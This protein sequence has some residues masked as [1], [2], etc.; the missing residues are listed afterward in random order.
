MTESESAQE[1]ADRHKEAGNSFGYTKNAD[2][3]I[4]MWVPEGM[5]IS[6]LPEVGGVRITIRKFPRE[7]KG[8][9]RWI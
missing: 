9:G 6:F 7:D 3:T 8:T 1:Y 5:D 2:G 4:S